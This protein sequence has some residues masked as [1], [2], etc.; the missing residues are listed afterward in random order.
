MATAADPLAQFTAGQSRTRGPLRNWAQWVDGAVHELR[1][2]EDLPDDVLPS[3]LQSA[4]RQ[5]ASRQGPERQGYPPKRVHTSL[6]PGA[7]S[8]YVE[9]GALFDAEVRR[10]AIE[11][12]RELGYPAEH[13]VEEEGRSRPQAAGDASRVS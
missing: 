9:P 12:G 6:K 3:S 7:L 1:F 10:Q 11:R 2:G 8:V 5:W 13:L 4:F